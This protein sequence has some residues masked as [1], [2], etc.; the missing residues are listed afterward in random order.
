MLR[1][2]GSVLT[3]V[4]T[5]ALAAA[6]SAEPRAALVCRG[7]EPEWTLRIDGGSASFAAL[8]GTGLEQAAFE[9]RVEETP[10]PARSFVYRGRARSSASDLVA[11]ITPE[12]CVDTMADAAEGGGRFEYT[13]R[14]S[15]P[16][17]A[18]RVGCCSLGESRRAPG[19]ATAVGQQP[20][21]DAASAAAAT[22][23]GEITLVTLS[24]ETPCKPPGTGSELRHR[25]W[26]VAFDCGRSAGDT[27]ALVG[28][29]TLGPGGLLVA[30]KVLV[31]WRSGEQDPQRTESVP[32]R[33][34][35]ITLASGLVCRFAGKGATLAFEGQRLAYSCGT[36]D[37]DSVALLGE[38]ESAADGFRI[39]RARI[40]H[41]DS[42]FT[43]RSSEPIPVAVPR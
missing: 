5:E 20:P 36:K 27:L 30:Q 35:E 23:R 33:A 11:V 13:A 32:A 15:L 14:V 6:G 7:H 1:L 25:G 29:F 26:R 22:D 37:G 21:P 3:I 40:A 38:L 24:D 4:L 18:S 17:G 39:L 42:G 43:L 41:G 31:P 16:D 10:G 9:G 28:P 12:A 8:A 19:T 2:A 34:A